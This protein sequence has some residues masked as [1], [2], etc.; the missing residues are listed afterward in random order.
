MSEQKNTWALNE[1]LEL[2]VNEYA[3]ENADSL[4]KI[5]QNSMT[6]LGFSD[7]DVNEWKE[8]RRREQK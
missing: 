7:F 4:D 2:V 6:A 8:N 1:L 3:K 5:L